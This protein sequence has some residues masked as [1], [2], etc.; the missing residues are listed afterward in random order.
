MQ[1]QHVLVTG[2]S[3]YLAGF[4]ILALLKQGHR[5]RST[6]RTLQRE[7]AV[8]ATLAP[9]TQAMESLEFV[10]AD[11]LQDAGWAQATAGVQSVL[12]VASPM[13]MGAGPVDL[14]RPA[15]E[16]TR[17]VLDAA[18][19]AGVKRVVVT[20]SLLAALPADA[21]K[22]Q[23]DEASWTDLNG[24]DINMYTQSKTLAERDAWSWAQE[25]PATQLTT[26]LPGFIQG[27]VLGADYSESLQVVAR[28]LTGKVPALPRLGF[29]IVDVRDLADLHVQAMQAAGAAGHRFTASSDF[30]WMTDM[31]RALRDSLGAGAAKVPTRTLP[32]F[33]VKAAARFNPE[34]REVLPDLGKQRSCE[35]LKARRLLGFAP[36]PAVESIVDC[37]RSLLDGGLLGAA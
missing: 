27:P 5:V 14:L 1:Q 13:G 24:R 6:L 28:M 7:A 26:L 10:A 15:R 2:G 18:A 4:V 31:A 35:A 12:H 16:G 23:L 3:G 34:L 21:R 17:R 29:C 11:L 32:D 8:R 20:S 30:L 36:R 25:H 37:G 19:H 9:H 33:L 22:T